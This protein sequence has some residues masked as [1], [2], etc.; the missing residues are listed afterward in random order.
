MM[1]NNY[2]ADDLSKFE[3]EAAPVSR[4]TKSTPL[5][6]PRH[7]ADFVISYRNGERR[8]YSVKSFTK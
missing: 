3:Q 8:L 2:L 1:I 4:V 7:Y 5:D 6:A